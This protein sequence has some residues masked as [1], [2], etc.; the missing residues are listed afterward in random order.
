MTTSTDE[1][2]PTTL[3]HPNRV[4]LDTPVKRGKTLIEYVDLRKPC[5]GELRGISLG[6]LAQLDVASLIKLL[7]RISPLTSQ[8]V[9]ALEP[10]D[11]MAFGAKVIDFLLQKQA[12]NDAFLTA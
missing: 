1:Q 8:E 6:D 10:A 11:L 9:A 2:D 7:P 4:F 5:S 3:E 12:K